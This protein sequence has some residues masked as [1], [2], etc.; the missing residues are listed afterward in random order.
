MTGQGPVT[1]LTAEYKYRLNGPVFGD[2]AVMAAASLLKDPDSFGAVVGRFEAGFAERFGLSS[3]SAVTNATVAYY[4]M[5]VG[6]QYS[7][8]AR[9][10]TRFLRYRCGLPLHIH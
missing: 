10:R 6:C 4:T 8:A 7:G 3:V 2:A 1:V 9:R 5:C